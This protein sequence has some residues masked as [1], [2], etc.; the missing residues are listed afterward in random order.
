MRKIKNKIITFIEE[1]RVLNTICSMILFIFKLVGY[2]LCQLYYHWKIT[3][4]TLVLICMH[5]FNLHQELVINFVNFKWFLINISIFDIVSSFIKDLQYNYIFQV[6]YGLE[7]VITFILIFW[8]CRHIKLKDY[9]Q[10]E[11]KKIVGFKNG[12]NEPPF[13]ISLNRLWG[14]LKIEKMT[15]DTNGIP[16]KKIMESEIKESLGSSLQRTIVDAYPVKN[17]NYKAIVLTAPDKYKTETKNID[18]SDS[19]ISKNNFELILGENLKEKIKININKTPHVLVGGTTGSG[20]SVIINCLA[21]QCAMKGAILCF[22]DLKELDYNTWDNKTLTEYNYLGD[23]KETLFPNQCKVST[24]LKNIS[25]DLANIMFE[26]GE[27]KRIFKSCNCKN[28]N[29]YN[30]LYPDKALSR[31][32]FIFDE[33][34]AL[35][36]EN[37]NKNIVKQIISDISV[38]ATRGRAFGIHLILGAQRP[39]TDTIKGQIRSN[40]DIRIC[41]RASDIYMSEIVL[42]KGNHDASTL[43]GRE[44]VGIFVTND[45]KRFKGYNFELPFDNEQEDK[46]II[47]AEISD[48]TETEVED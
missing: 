5:I 40:L 41:G 3:L 43:I 7:L 39:D 33:F 17:S 38:I 13:V 42:G 8:L 18:F 47:K 21:Y 2:L 29:E 27:R 10:K 32:I 12:N 23:Y 22:A 30:N 36:D 46:D 37:L 11:L 28:I 24:D 1:H 48:I 15:L 16:P 34:E 45:N 44:D 20:K 26:Y 9:K 14:N 25:N 6:V 4:I 19:Y 35:Q 31:I